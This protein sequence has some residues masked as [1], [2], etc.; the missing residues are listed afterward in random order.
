MIRIKYYATERDDL[1]SQLSYSDDRTP[2]S[3]KP[4]SEVSDKI[5]TS[6]PIFNFANFFGQGIDLYDET[7]ELGD[8]TDYYGFIPQKSDT[9]QSLTIE[10]EAVDGEEPPKLD[11]GITIEFHKHTCKR[12]TVERN[13]V[14][15]GTAEDENGLPEKVHI[16]FQTAEDNWSDIVIAFSG[17]VD[18][19]PINLKGVVLGK[20]IDIDNIMAFDMIAETNPI[21]DDLALNE[22]NVT[23]IVD[24]DFTEYEGQKIVLFDNDNILEN[25]YLSKTSEIDENVYDIKSRSVFSVLGKIPVQYNFDAV[26][27]MGWDG[28]EDWVNYN[29]KF[30]D[31]INKDLKGVASIEYPTEIADVMLSPFLAKGNARKVLQ[32]IAWASCCRFDTTYSEKIK[33]IPFFASETTAP[34]IVISNSDDRILKTAITI[35]EQYSKIVWEKVKYSLNAKEGSFETLATFSVLG[36]EIQKNNSVLVEF[37]EPCIPIEEFSVPDWKIVASSPYSCRLEYQFSPDVPFYPNEDYGGVINGYRYS[38]YSEGTEIK[39][40]EKGET[41]KITDQLLYPIDD[42]KKIAQLKKWYSRNNT[43]SA[44]VVDDDSEIRVGKIVK[45]QL[46]NGKYFQGIVTSIVRNN[47]GDYHTVDLEAHEWN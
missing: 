45:I 14:V 47:I 44:T 9:A 24:E 32:Q 15:L 38:Q 11:N 18:D 36:S 27:S 12:I 2:I 20:I 10:F 28:I 39:V 19:S 13:G 26:S 4:L 25:D 41:L 16:D 29:R 33:F 43:L 7:I 17:M 3:I 42:T 8:E 34:D 40:S 6:A 23:A 31:A 5:K 30:S 46:K 1:K 21:S 37:K 22:T 35:G